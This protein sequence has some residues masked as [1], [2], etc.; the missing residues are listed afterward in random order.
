MLVTE[1]VNGTASWLNQTV[2]SGEPLHVENYRKK[3]A[4]VVPTTL[5]EEAEAALQRERARKE[6]TAA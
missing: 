6:V 1:F 3:H 5:W 4:T 2:E